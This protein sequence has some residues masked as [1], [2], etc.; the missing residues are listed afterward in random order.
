MFGGTQYATRWLGTP[1]IGALAQ[2]LPVEHLEAVRKCLAATQSAVSVLIGLKQAFNEL[3]DVVNTHNVASGVSKIAGGA[4][5]VVGGVACALA[6][7]IFG[8]SFVVGV[9]CLAASMATGIGAAIGDKLR[10]DEF[11]ERLNTLQTRL[12]TA[13][14]AFAEH[15]VSYLQI[16]ALQKHTVQHV[17]SMSVGD[18][19]KLSGIGVALLRNSGVIVPLAAGAAQFAVRLCAACA[20]SGAQVG[21]GQAMEAVGAVGS[22]LGAAAGAALAVGCGVVGCVPSNIDIVSGVNSLTNGHQCVPTLN[23][24][25]SNVGE[26]IEQIALIKVQLI[27][28]EAARIAGVARMTAPLPPRR[29]RQQHDT[30]LCGICQE[31]V[32]PDAMPPRVWIMPYLPMHGP[33]GLSLSR[34]SLLPTASVCH[35]LRHI[36]RGH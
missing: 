24:L 23:S 30:P 8:A 16:R 9:P 31:E 4:T 1:E 29:T 2:Q 10:G 25:I 3:L 17:E 20:G 32:G 21:G 36:Q 28:A 26:V 7:F 18:L 13:H 22:G 27:T 19:A 6:L 11:N 5:G 35:N 15:L 14:G 34:C 12:Q 33:L